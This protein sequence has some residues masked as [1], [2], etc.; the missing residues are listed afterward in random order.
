MCGILMLGNL[1]QKNCFVVLFLLKRK[2]KSSWT[3]HFYYCK[4]FVTYI[5][6]LNCF[7][8]K[9]FPEQYHIYVCIMPQSY[10]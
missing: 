4:G 5:P 2:W 9:N 7:A 10:A 1:D 8:R 3:F 6:L